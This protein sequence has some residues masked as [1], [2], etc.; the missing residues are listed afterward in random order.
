MGVIEVRTAAVPDVVPTLRTLAADIAM[1]QDFDLDAIEDLRMAVDE[2]C[3]LLLGSAIEGTMTC[4]FTTEPGRVEV[5]VTV[6]VRSA[7]LVEQTSLTWQL[8]TALAT[9]AKRTVTPEDGGFVA[10][11]DLVRECATAER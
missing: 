2:A 8:L 1:R 10:R 6:P 11:I 9:S 3:S 4:V 5:V 7:E